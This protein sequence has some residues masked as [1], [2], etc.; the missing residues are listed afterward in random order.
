M[1]DEDWSVDREWLCERIVARVGEA[2][3]FADTAGTI[4]LWNDAAEQI[5]GYEPREAIG[6]SLDIIL[7]EES[8]EAHWRGYDAAIDAGETT[9]PPLYLSQIPAVREDG[10][11]I[12]IET[13]SAKVVTDDDGEPVGSFVT[14]RD[15]TDEDR[16]TLD[17]DQRAR[18]VEHLR[19]SPAGFGYEQQSW[20]PELVRHHVEEEYGVD[21]S[22]SHAYS[23]LD[24]ADPDT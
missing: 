19:A 2:V 8:R 17:A 23:L 21:L 15:L 5:F 13:S 11:R 18:V 4:R 22:V 20:S 12:T 1:Y 14:I 3:V 16:R 10:E 7:P 9:S 24:Q 6:E